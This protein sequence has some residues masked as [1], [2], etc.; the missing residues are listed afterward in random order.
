[1]PWICV[2]RGGQQQAREMVAIH[3]RKQRPEAI[4]TE[5]GYIQNEGLEE[6][7]MVVACI[8]NG[9]REVVKMD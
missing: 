9:W 2:L 7:E 6:I 1:M 3:T 8:L 5:V 4:K